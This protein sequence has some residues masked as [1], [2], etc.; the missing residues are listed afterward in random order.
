MALYF[1]CPHCDRGVVAEYCENVVDYERGLYKCTECGGILSIE[2]DT[3]DY[4]EYVKIEKFDL[5]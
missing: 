4:E 2:N 5:V 3:I 1:R